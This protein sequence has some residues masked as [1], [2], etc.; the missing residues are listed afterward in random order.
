[1]AAHLCDNDELT[2]RQLLDRAIAALVEIENRLRKTQGGLRTRNH[3]KVLEFGRR[4][5]DEQDDALTRLRSS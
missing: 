3:D 2:E 5:P 1:M 4:F